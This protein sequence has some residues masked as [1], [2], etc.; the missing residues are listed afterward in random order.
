MVFYVE[1]FVVDC[2]YSVVALVRVLSFFLCS[3]VLSDLGW[4]VCLATY[5]IGLSKSC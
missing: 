2:I 4:L 3:M 1:F 5:P